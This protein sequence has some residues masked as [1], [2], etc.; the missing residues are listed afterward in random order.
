MQ[1]FINNSNFVF[2]ASTVKNVTEGKGTFIQVITNPA[3]TQPAMNIFHNDFSAFSKAISAF[4][5]SR[6]NHKDCFFFAGNTQFNS[7]E[8]YVATGYRGGDER[9]ENDYAMGGDQFRSLVTAGK[10]DHKDVVI[11]GRYYRLMVR[12]E[13]VSAHLCDSKFD[14]ARSNNHDYNSHALLTAYTT[15]EM[16]VNAGINYNLYYF[17]TQAWLADSLME[18]VNGGRDVARNIIIETNTKAQAA[19]HVERLVVAQNN[20]QK[21]TSYGTKIVSLLMK[22]GVT[23]KPYSDLVGKNYYQFNKLTGRKASVGQLPEICNTIEEAYNIACGANGR[24]TFQIL[25]DVVSA[26]VSA[27]VES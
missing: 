14:P 19:Q 20:T 1:N 23:T 16:W 26:P 7:F 25:D 8:E 6:Y 27:P 2:N 21:Y 18:A 10:V 4:I 24:F 17:D 5:A 22:D 13:R 15:I 9:S 12:G 3:S 11:S